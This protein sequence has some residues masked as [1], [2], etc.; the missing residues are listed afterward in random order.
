MSGLQ[1]ESRN[2]LTVSE[3]SLGE[4]S[5]E[6]ALVSSSITVGIGLDDGW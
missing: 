4:G 2:D 5:P 1:S 3:T 6:S